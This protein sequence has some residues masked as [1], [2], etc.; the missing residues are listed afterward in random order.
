MQFFI[1]LTDT[2]NKTT[3]FYNQLFHS[4]SAAQRKIAEYSKTFLSQGL[5]FMIIPYVQNPFY[6]FTFERKQW[7][8]FNHYFK[9]GV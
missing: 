8:S 3:S 9:K 6:N 7:L 1:T 2:K 5:F 4:Y